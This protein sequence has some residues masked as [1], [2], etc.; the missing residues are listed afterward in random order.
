MSDPNTDIV[1]PETQ[2]AKAPKKAPPR[3]GELPTET[4][5]EKAPKAT[6]PAPEPKPAWEPNELVI[7][8]MN[9]IAAIDH[10]DKKGIAQVVKAAIDLRTSAKATRERAELAGDES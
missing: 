8:A 2:A 10:T 5:S 9:A 1:T 7:A 4:A 6:K 3:V